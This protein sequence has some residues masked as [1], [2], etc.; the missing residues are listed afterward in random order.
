MDLDV[1]I[2]GPCDSFSHRVLAIHLYCRWSN[3][4][5]LP[6]LLVAAV[7]ASGAYLIV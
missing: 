7:E 2:G 6:L 3:F 1:V 4:T 5:I